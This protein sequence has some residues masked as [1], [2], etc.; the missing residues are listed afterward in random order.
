MQAKSVT[1]FVMLLLLAVGGCKS[2]TSEDPSKTK[3]VEDDRA[4]VKQL[5]SDLVQAQQKNNQ[6]TEQITFLRGISQDRWSHLVRVAKI[7]FGRF[8]R[9]D[10]ADDNGVDDVVIVY[11]QL[12]DKQGDKIKA[13]GE[14]FFELWDLADSDGP[15]FRRWD[16]GLEQ[17]PD[18]WLGGVMANHYKFLLTWP[19]EK[20]L[21][22]SNLTLKCRFTD[23]LSGEVF[24]TQKM[25][26]LSINH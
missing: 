16:F 23:A 21:Q 18:Y 3:V 24:E 14:V 1:I 2:F 19:A 26:E 17:L 8:T 13:A 11:L 5:R 20:L 15:M 12:V 4:E 22:H 6:L 25:I 9:S 10:D 7:Q